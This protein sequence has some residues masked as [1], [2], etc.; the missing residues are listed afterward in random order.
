MTEKSSQEDIERS[1]RLF[2]LLA[3]EEPPVDLQSD[4]APSKTAPRPAVVVER[5]SKGGYLLLGGMVAVLLVT[6]VVTAVVFLVST[7]DHPEISKTEVVPVEIAGESTSVMPTPVPTEIRRT[8]TSV[9]DATIVSPEA[10]TE[11][12]DQQ[13][14]VLLPTA[15]VDEVAV[16]L[17]QPPIQVSN[18]ITVKVEPFTITGQTGRTQVITYTVQP[19]DTLS[20]IAETFNLDEC[21]LV[22]SNPRNRVSPLRPGNVLNILPVDGVFFKVVE[23]VTIQQVADQTQVSAYSIIDS[24]YNQLLGLSPETVL[25]EGMKIVVPEGSGGDCNIWTAPTVNA[26]SSTSDGSAGG[27]GPT[28]GSLWG[29]SYSGG[30]GG[31]PSSNPIGGS[32]KFWQGFSS[33]HTGVDLSAASGTPVLAAGGGTVAFAGWTDGGYGNAIVIDHGGSYSLYAHLSSINVRCGQSVGAQEVIGGVGSTG[34]SSG[35][36]LHFEIRD[37]GFNPIDPAYSISGGL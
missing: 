18:G 31:F 34:R 12:V 19:G 22:W 26:S 21:T 4:T 32:Y 23:E 33:G 13:F 3:A 10:E 7:D 6:I 35:A 37:A 24:P 16:A 5:R 36:H 17:S 27:G 11:M 20:R 25:V 9:P 8:P 28:G 2:E 29:C 30:A 15:A 1:E 14:P